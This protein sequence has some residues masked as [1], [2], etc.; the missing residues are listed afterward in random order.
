MWYV[1]E[2]AVDTSLKIRFQV[3]PC[4]D[5]DNKLIAMKVIRH[6]ELWGRFFLEVFARVLFVMNL[7]R[8]GW[9]SLSGID[10]R[11]SCFEGFVFQLWNWKML[12]SRIAMISG[13]LSKVCQQRGFFWRGG[14][15]ES[16]QF[17]I[18]MPQG[19]YTT[20]VY[21]KYLRYY[22]ILYINMMYA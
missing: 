2:I 6:Q 22:I 14:W 20:H 10:N 4:A 12:N 17:L 8:F 18:G 13:P 3:W 9:L 5:K 7:E 15:L 19:M 21:H 1:E 11:F 16:Q